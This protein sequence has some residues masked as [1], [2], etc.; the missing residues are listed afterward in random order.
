M[1]TNVAA[2]Q[3]AWTTAKGHLS[4]FQTDLA[5]LLTDL[6]NLEADRDALENLGA[7]DVADWLRIQIES[8]CVG[9]QPRVSAGAGRALPAQVRV[10]QAKNL[11]VARDLSIVDT[12]PVS[13]TAT[14]AWANLS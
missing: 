3:A 5:T 12:R 13:S 6:Q 9:N 2:V 4:T 11:N 1:P 10:C 14:G 7:G 8:A